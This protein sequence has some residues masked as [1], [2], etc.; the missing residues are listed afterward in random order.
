MIKCHD[1]DLSHFDEASSY[2]ITKLSLCESSRILYATYHN[3]QRRARY[4]Y[5]SDGFASEKATR[6]TEQEG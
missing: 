6:E 4:V 2:V 1:T 3:G 5:G